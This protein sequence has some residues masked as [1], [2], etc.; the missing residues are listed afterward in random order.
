MPDNGD[1]IQRHAQA[2]SLY[3]QVH[4]IKVTPDA[5][6]SGVS[7]EQ[8]TDPHYPRLQEQRVYYPWNK[9]RIGQLVSF[10][11]WWKLYQHAIR[12]YIRV[13]GRPDLV[14]VHIPFKAGLI[15]L[16]LRKRYRLPF[17]VTEHWGGYNT[18]V[19]GNYTT[20]GFLFKW[21]TRQTFAKAVGFHTVSQYL[22]EQVNRY[23]G[24][25]NYTV[26]PNVVDT[27]LFQP[28]NR[29]TDGSSKCRLLHISNGAAVKN[30][31][32]II[33]AFQ[34]L[35]PEQ[36]SLTV[37][38]L[39][40]ADNRRLSEAHPEITFTGIQPYRQ[41]AATLQHCDILLLFSHMENS[42]CV[43]G[44]AFCCGKPVIA[45]NVGG[46]PELGDAANSILI[47]PGDIVALKE[48]IETMK[49]TY[50]KFD[51]SLMAAQAAARFSYETIGL[52]LDQ[53]YRSRLQEQLRS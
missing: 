50:T 25:R 16:W 20:K 51:S 4:V 32:G 26:I 10:Y 19:A 37:V 52:S 35:D 17:V 7:I 22:G 40:E 29:S 47:A 11:R 46:I 18:V 15:A 1:F 27:S 24:Q 3:H 28:E 2:A 30:L 33:A 8:R 41:V 5:Q 48:A 21:I 42:P 23:I 44:E 53:W 38:G 34:L 9:G 13:N 39:Q 12:E 14:H 31:P 45:P 43:I 6:A 36:F 49:A